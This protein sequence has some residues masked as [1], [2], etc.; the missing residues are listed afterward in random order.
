MDLAS[1][2]KSTTFIG[3]DIS[4][5]F[6]QHVKP[7]NASFVQYNVL[8][9]IPFPNNT[10]DYV[11]QSL[12]SSSFT[13]SQ[14][15]E[16]IKEI[17]RVTKPGGWIEFLEYDYI[18][19]NKGPIVQRINGS[20]ISFFLS[21]GLIPNISAH[22]PE[23]MQSNDQLMDVRCEVKSVPLGNWGGSLGS[24]VCNIY[25]FILFIIYN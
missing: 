9:K 21:Q 14:W 13:T 17:V 8:N 25:I 22:L 15:K 11:H 16:V 24:V 19:H 2:Y 4:P 10:F 20:T 5:M 23:F 1:K 18:V 3:L 7:R 12:L 6:P